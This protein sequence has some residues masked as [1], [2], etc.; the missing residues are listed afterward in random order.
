[1][2]V[3]LTQDRRPRFYLPLKRDNYEDWA[4]YTR[5]LLRRDKIWDIVDPDIKAKDVAGAEVDETKI[6]KAQAILLDRIGW[7]YRHII[8]QANTPREAWKTLKN[9]L[10]PVSASRRARLIR[11]ISNIKMKTTL[12]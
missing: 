8:R 9:T 5:L 6:W 1:M 4:Y 12:K 7:K 10:A 2:E 11:E 3:S